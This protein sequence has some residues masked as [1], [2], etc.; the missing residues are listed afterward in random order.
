MSKVG[1]GWNRAR[2]VSAIGVACGGLLLGVPEDSGPLAQPS[3]ATIVG[4]VVFQ[5]TVPGPKT[6]AV[7]RDPEVCGS[8]LTVQPLT[9]EQ[10][11]HGVQHVVVSL[12]DDGLTGEPGTAV[13]GITNSKCRFQPRISVGQLGGTIEIGNHDPVIHNTHI[14]HNGRTFINVALI[15]GSKPIGKAFK[16]AG[17]HK[18][19]C[20]AHK[21]ME[22][23]L[24]VFEHPYFAVTN[25]IGQFRLT[26]VPAGTR[27]VTVWHETLGT[28]RQEITV[29]AGGEV[30]MKFEYGS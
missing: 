14:T 12:A 28:L 1:N 5:G 11:T 25:D 21:F 20:N 24:H 9:V 7:T 23:Y 13:A 27:E 10:E 30:R 19:R 6:I 29:P 18:V 8:T 2:R 4:T 22:G 15:A 3:G 26:G 17:L 16:S